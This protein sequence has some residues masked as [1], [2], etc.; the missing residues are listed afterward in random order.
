MKLERPTYVELDHDLLRR[1]ARA[2]HKAGH[3]KDWSRLL[4]LAERLQYP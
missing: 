1:V 3:Y 2:L 4:E